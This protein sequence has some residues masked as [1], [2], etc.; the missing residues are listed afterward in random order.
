MLFTNFC[1]LGHVSLI[2]PWFKFSQLCGIFCFLK[3]TGVRAE[4][5]LLWSG[6]RNCWFRFRKLN[7]GFVR[8]SFGKELLEEAEGRSF[9]K[10][11]WNGGKMEGAKGAV[12][13][14]CGKE[15]LEGVL[16]RSGW[17]ELSQGAREGVVG[18]SRGKS[19]EKG[20]AARCMPQVL[21]ECQV[22][23]DSLCLYH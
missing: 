6:L 16:G 3:Y 11:F 20:A 12:G 7:K 18:R 22:H 17:K 19:G 14:S 15:L 1:H 2:K 8:R 13:R 21:P 23:I 5:H 10:Y 9:C 4:R